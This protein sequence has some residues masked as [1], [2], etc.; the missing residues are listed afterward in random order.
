MMT[1]NNLIGATTG[2]IVVVI[3]GI[4]VKKVN[5]AARDKVLA[6]Y[7]LALFVI[8]FWASFE[9]AGNAMNVWADQATDRYV[10]STAAE[11]AM[12]PEVGKPI[13]FD[14]VAKPVEAV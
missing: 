12:L 7:S 11:P 13:G 10:S 3:A 14:D 8:F 2:S 1:G 6:I 5:G 9:Q 4:I